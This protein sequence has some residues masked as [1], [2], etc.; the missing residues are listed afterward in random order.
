MGICPVLCATL[1]ARATKLINLKIKRMEKH[2]KSWYVLQT[3]KRIKDQELN[4]EKWA[5]YICLAVV[6]LWAL[7][8]ISI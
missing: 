2:Q 5:F 8:A 7:L 1:N 4:F 6:A 3:E